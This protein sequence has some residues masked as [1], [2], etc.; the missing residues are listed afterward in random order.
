MVEPPYSEANHGVD[1]F[2]LETGSTEWVSCDVSL[3]I[4]GAMSFVATLPET[5]NSL[6][7]SWDLPITFPASLLGDLRGML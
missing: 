1:G 2:P 3:S 7:N 6:N 4:F 5:Q